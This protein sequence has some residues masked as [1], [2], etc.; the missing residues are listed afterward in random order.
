M[1]HRNEMYSMENRINI[2]ISRMVI[3]D[4]CLSWCTSCN[5]GNNK[6]LCYTPGTNIM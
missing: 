5:V 6:S 3:D 4:N 2:V 1:N